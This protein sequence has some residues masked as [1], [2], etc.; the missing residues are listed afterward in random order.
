MQL[1]KYVKHTAYLLSVIISRHSKNK[2]MRM[3]INHNELLAQK[4]T[5]GEA[6]WSANLFHINGLHMAWEQSKLEIPYILAIMDSLFCRSNDLQL[7][8]FCIVLL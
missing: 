2:S 5:Y 8:T 7:V 1:Q 4:F 3:I 6:K